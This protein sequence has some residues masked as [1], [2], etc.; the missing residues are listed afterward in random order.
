MNLRAGPL[1]AGALLL[2]ACR[3]LPPEQVPLGAD[4]ARPAALLEALWRRGEEVRGLRG[5]A[6]VSL[7]GQ[8]GASFAKQLVLLERPARLRVEVLGMLG[9]RV[10]IL[11]T[12]GIG[13][14]LYRAESAGVESG[15]VDEG[16]L[17][18]TL[19]LALTPEEVVGLALGAPL[20]R[21]EAP[22]AAGAVS[23]PADGR[24]RV[25]LAGAPDGPREVV[26]F[27][28]D[29]ALARYALR[30][31]EGRPVFEARYGDYRPVGGTAFAHSI[32]LDFP[33]SEARAAIQFSAVELNPEVSATLF[34][35]DEV[36][37]GPGS[38]REAPWRSSA[39]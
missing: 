35:L 7:E 20:G 2:G 15:R 22:R 10:A 12:D 27:D 19:G 11:A 38:R 28:A 13:Y 21:D 18:E 25:A 33:R 4:D 1:L 34:R 6:R 32:D 37:G 23:F 36:R 3:T 14:D 9:Q 30:D 16:T 5:R 8:R 31:G 24:V 29:G 17:W 39:S 26:D